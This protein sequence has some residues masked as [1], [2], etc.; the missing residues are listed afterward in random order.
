[1]NH[2]PFTAQINQS[3]LS[4]IS[5]FFDSGLPDIFSE[6][7]Q[8]AR[9]AGATRVNVSLETD[10]NTIRFSDNGSGIS[11]PKVLLDYGANG[12]DE[13]TVTREDAAG[14]GFLCLA[15]RNPVISSRTDL[16]HRDGFCLT[17]TNEQFTGDLPA[18]PQSLGA[19][20]LECPISSDPVR[21]SRQRS[22]TRI[23]FE[24]THE[25][26]S[27]DPGM[28]NATELESRL[29]HRALA[30]AARY[31]PLEIYCEGFELEREDFLANAIHLES[32]EGVHIGIFVDHGHQRYRDPEL[33]Y[34]GNTVSGVCL[35]YLNPVADISRY[36]RIDVVGC[37]KLKM[38]LPARR[39][40]I[41]NDFLNELHAH[42]RTVLLRSLESVPC[43][44]LAYQDYR[45]ALQ[46]GI[47]VQ[48][49]APRLSQWKPEYCDCQTSPGVRTS[50]INVEGE[51]SLIIDLSEPSTT[52]VLH[53]AVQNSPDI[54]ETQL[55]SP[56]YRLAGY[57]W[58][59]A[60]PQ[61]RGV[62]A[63]ITVDG[64]TYHHAGAY[65]HGRVY[66]FAA[67]GDD[68]IPI[69]QYVNRNSNGSVVD[70]IQLHLYTAIDESGHCRAADD[71]G[72]YH[73]NVVKTLPADI[74]FL[75]E[76]T[77]DM[78]VPDSI[79]PLV[80]R[81]LD[82]NT[83]ELV[84]LT[85]YAYFEYLSDGSDSDSFDTQ[86]RDFRQI[87]TAMFWDLVLDPQESLQRRIET[88]IRNLAW[89]LPPNCPDIVVRFTG[90]NVPSI[91]I[92]DKA[93]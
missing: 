33:N 31:S 1:M 26:L 85:E 55:F 93:A 25:E 64:N 43:N 2:Q 57:D 34:Y 20:M 49:A 74:Y 70:D 56:N 4:R 82:V 52:Q 59:D 18:E 75:Q 36:A 15:N 28:R 37:P 58:Y 30:N 39:E 11:D 61:V 68:T 81:G 53:H 8:N 54:D 44:S 16:L 92:L 29:F 50:T 87:V 91:E 90:P 88:Q 6:L 67:P 12:W 69:D 13:N 60:I 78:Y 24:L 40:I 73:Y 89:R 65:S 19:L 72:T 14:M 35:P 3:M 86:R 71:G 66:D 22:G 23:D 76:D 48:P 80:R 84:D 83:N 63:H 21:L 42:V 46:L 10:T 27:P 41:K 45:D 38:V 7:L 51:N 9:R 32:W 5:R 79:C 77:V 17:L 62:A 47:N